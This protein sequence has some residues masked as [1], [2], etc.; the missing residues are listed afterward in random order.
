MVSDGSPAFQ[1][2]V[3]GSGGGPSEGNVSGYLVRSTSKHWAK[4]SLLA[5]DA[6]THLSGIIRIL[7]NHASCFS[8]SS[9]SPSPE[10]KESDDT[11]ADA[12]PFSGA[13][14]PS[15]HAKVNASYIVSELVSTYLLTHTHLDHL[16]G[17]VINTAALKDTKNPKRLAAL[18]HVINAVKSHIFN[19]VIWPNLSDED[20]GVGLITYQ[21][22][23][24]AQNYV[25]VCEGLSTQAWPVSHGHCMKMHTHW[26]RKS[27]AGL[28]PCDVASNQHGNHQP[29]WCVL[30]SAV[31]FVRDEATGKE[32]MMWGDVEPDSISLDPRNDS[33]WEEA[34]RK[35]CMGSLCAIFIE[36]SYDNTQPDRALYGHLSPS[37][38]IQELKALAAYVSR[39]RAAKEKDREKLKRK[40]MSNGYFNEDPE[41][42]CRRRSNP[43]SPEVMR[44]EFDTS[45]SRDAVSLP[46][47]LEQMEPGVDVDISQRSSITIPGSD[48]VVSKPLEGLQIVVT[49]VK[50]TLT[51]EDTPAKILAELQ[52]LEEKTNLGCTFKLAV[53]GGSMY[54]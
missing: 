40:R 53:Q 17:F 33:V 19:D 25:S 30:D 49:H 21:R 5:V 52:A 45:A 31:Y 37:H 15:E 51:N 43:N 23:N 13:S 16:S 47:F 24:V 32:L 26:G 22:L 44:Q 27:S 18:P 20:A 8:R 46:P 48:L 34:A 41:I 3:L 54:F 35:V 7:E 14:L 11:T 28:D 42:E 9:T 29:R 12:F 36:C 39:F 4:N 1:V 50:D 2:V 10:C 6:G 38:L